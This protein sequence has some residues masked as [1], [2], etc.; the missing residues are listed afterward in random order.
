MDLKADF[1]VA[2]KKGAGERYA[3]EAPGNSHIPKK[4]QKSPF[5]ANTRGRVSVC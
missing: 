3:R 4:I 5:L 2:H 1:A